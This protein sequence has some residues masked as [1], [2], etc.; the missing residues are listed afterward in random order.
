[1]SALLF[2]VSTSLLALPESN[3]RRGAFTQRPLRKASVLLKSNM[4]ETKTLP[5]AVERLAK[6]AQL[7]PKSIL[8]PNR[9]TS[10]RL[11]HYSFEEVTR[12]FH[13]GLSDREAPVV[14]YR[15]PAL[16]CPYCQRVQFYLEERKIAYRTVHIPMRCYETEE[17]PK[18]RWYLAM[19]PSGLL[20][21]VKLVP[22]GLLLT[23]SLDIMEFFEEQ[24]SFRSYP[25]AYATDTS[26][27]RRK[28]ELLRLERR[29]FADWLRYLTGSVFLA[30]RLRQEFLQTMDAVE[31]AIGE[32]PNAPF[33]SV[34]EKGND[35]GPG[36]VDCAIAP[37]LERIEYSI[38]FW[39]GLEIR[40]NPR[41][42]RLEEW[43]QAIESRPSYLKANA[44]S[45][46]MNLP[47]QIGRCTTS[48][49]E[50]EAATR[51]QEQV[52]HE[53]EHTQWYEYRP[54]QTCP[55]DVREARLEAAAAIIRNFARVVYD[56][57]KHCR[58][59]ESD[60]GSVEEA[61]C[62]AAQVLIEGSA[63]NAPPV[64]N[65]VAREALRHIRGR[66]CVP[67]DLSLHSAR[68]F[69]G[70]INALLAKGS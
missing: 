59:A 10:E 56:M 29:L 9:S 49:A 12:V 34:L 64:V 37:F 6:L 20:P 19:V 28:D 66:V 33:L 40:K 51:V 14:L 2:Q 46:V 24:R 7:V 5:A 18:P 21:A 68:H 16:W 67:R 27:Q 23:E 69:W 26:E 60:D 50:L 35:P 36:L 1:M 52:I 25:A 8:N 15:D 31:R 45:T 44:Y 65:P 32:S 61:L 54:D 62:S 47:P 17:N 57:K 55:S 11:I 53:A 58:S 48:P 41:W 13:S 42:P 63:D 38:P 43:Y 3:Q 70:A 30:D 39:K 4:D 22:S